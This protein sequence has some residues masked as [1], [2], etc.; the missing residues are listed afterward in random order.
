MQQYADQHIPIPE[1]QKI[2]SQHRIFSIGLPKCD[3]NSEKRFP[4]TPEA[5]N[6]L[7]EKGFTIKMESG[8]ADSI[9][10][11]DNSYSRQ[12]AKIV[13]REESLMCDIVIH[14]A[15]LDNKDIKKLRRGALLL[16]ILH[17]ESQTREYVNALIQQGIIAVA[18]DLIGD[19]H[20]NKPFADILS[21]IDGR[22]A[23]AIAS[24]L[25]ADAVNGKGI[26]LGGIAGILPCEI[27]IIGS[28][29]AAVAAARSAMGAGAIVNMF[30]S[31]TYR[32]RAAL[33][34]LGNQT[35]GA[36]LH[37]RAVQKAFI[38]ADVVIITDVNHPVKFNSDIVST[39]KKGV[40]TFDLSCNEGT[41]FPS[42]P[43]V[44]LSAAKSGDNTIDGTTRVCYIHSGSAVPRTAAMALSDTFITMLDEIVTLD[45][46]SN[47]LKLSSGLQDA[48]FTFLGKVTNRKVAEVARMRAVDI[49]LL[50]QFS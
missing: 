2:Q 50:L 43:T 32:L 40:I 16:T 11:P 17:I 47:A 35:I 25:L 20:G 9:H 23:I 24:S 38:T 46:V 42:M 36:S 1:M 31:D 34:E 14:L 15:P 28:G 5:V 6:I 7:V 3:N 29:I 37:P 4:L 39:M 30:D 10:Y 12:G 49:R 41:T 21:E 13:S 22:S 26:L 18:I 19:E 48:V 44:N 33:K 27:T 45:G 8:A